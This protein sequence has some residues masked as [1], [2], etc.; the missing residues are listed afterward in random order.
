MEKINSRQLIIFTALFTIGTSLLVN[1]AH[2]SSMVKQDAWIASIWTSCLNVAYLLIYILLINKYPNH[3][4]LQIVDI[5]LGKWVGKLVSLLYIMF[6][7]LLTIFLL[8][9]LGEFM[10]TMILPSTPTWFVNI[11][12][13]TVIMIGLWYG[14]TTF[15]RSAELFFPI[16][17]IFLMIITV[18]LFLYGDYSKLLPIGEHGVLSIFAA[19]LK[20]S[21]FQEHICLLMTLSFFRTRGNRTAARSL[22]IGTILGSFVL[23]IFSVVTVIILGSYNTAHTLYPVF[24]VVK[25]ISIGDFFQRIE[26]LMI[27]VWFLAVFVKIYITYFASLV[28]MSEML[29]ISNYKPLI[30]P[31]GVVLVVYANIVYPNTATL[32]EFGSTWLSIVLIMGFLIPLLLLVID[33]IKQTFSNQDD[34]YELTELDGA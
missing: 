18:S 7:S 34:D 3:N 13:I 8:K 17:I 1:P 32:F 26:V 25:R 20:M 22:I 2:L 11:T 5:I 24:V 29:K 16:V 23:I 15:A 27:G 9:F 33:W 10:K 30:L 6:F 28:G 19:G 31:L 14:I 4:L 21:T 12:F